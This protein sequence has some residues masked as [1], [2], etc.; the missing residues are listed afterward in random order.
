MEK[1]PPRLKDR[2]INQSAK[3]VSCIPDD[4]V[5]TYLGCCPGKPEGLLMENR[6]IQPTPSHCSLH[7]KERK[8]KTKRNIVGKEFLVLL[9]KTLACKRG[10][11]CTVSTVGQVVATSFINLLGFMVTKHCC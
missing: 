6:H 11:G 7:Q 1:E 8:K 9:E 3:K 4:S 10:K 2:A 5:T